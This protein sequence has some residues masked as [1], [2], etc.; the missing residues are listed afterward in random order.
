MMIMSCERN[1]ILERQREGIAIAKAK[2]VYKGRRSKLTEE[3]LENM[4]IDFK[5]GLAKTEIAEKYDVTRAYVYQLV[6][7]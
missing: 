7:V 4:K 2:G 3:Q 6:N 1:I 5:S